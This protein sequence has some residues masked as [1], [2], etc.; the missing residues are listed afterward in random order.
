MQNAE[1][2]IRNSSPESSHFSLHAF[3]ISFVYSAL[4]LSSVSLLNIHFLTSRTHSFTK[5]TGI[6][7]S[8]EQTR[9]PGYVSFFRAVWSC[10]VPRRPLTPSFPPLRLSLLPPSLPPHSCRDRAD[11]RYGRTLASWFLLILLPVSWDFH[12]HVTVRMWNC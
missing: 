3:R 4:F 10:R 9:E 2:L 5:C 8:Q 7:H 6:S 1:V 11:L 12:L